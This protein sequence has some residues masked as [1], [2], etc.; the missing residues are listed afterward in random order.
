MWIIM[1][2]FVRPWSC[3]VGQIFKVKVYVGVKMK[4]CV[5]R[6]KTCSN[7]FV[8]SRG[9]RKYILLPTFNVSV[10]SYWQK[11]Q[12][13]GF[14]IYMGQKPKIYQILLKMVSNYSSQNTLPKQNICNNI[15]CS[16]PYQKGNIHLI[17]NV[18]LTE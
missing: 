2:K 14:D 17:H 18:N 10:L 5:N 11:G 16:L 13:S 8:V 6:V 9:F 4:I 15:I 12:R 3:C 1:E 7:I